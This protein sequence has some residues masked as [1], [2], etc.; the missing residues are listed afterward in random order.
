MSIK[1]EDLTP[2]WVEKRFAHLKAAGLYE[3]LS[4]KERTESLERMLAGVPKGE[5]VWL[6]GYGSL[7]WNPTVYYK[8]CRAGRVYGYH[9]SFCFW[10][11]SGRGTPEMPGLMLGLDRGGSCLGQAFRI[12]AREAR[13]EL[14]LIWRREMIGGAYRPRWITLHSPQGNARAITFVVNRGHRQYAGALTPEVT[15]HHIAR[16]E[17]WLGSCR[18]YLENTL[19]H[20]GGLGLSDSY[21]EHVHRL[22]Q[23]EE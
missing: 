12:R 11:Q 9:R 18:S 17:G 8:D 20:L 14:T 3:P 19:S 7:M 4:E 10:I 22:V 6:F 16:A 13:H 1:R 23:C 15:A 2:D 5:D 21:L